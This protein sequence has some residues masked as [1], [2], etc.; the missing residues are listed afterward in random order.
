MRFLETDIPGVVV[1]ELEPH[2]DERGFFARAFCVEEFAAR[3]LETRVAQANISYN[4]RA[5]TLRGLHW[6]VAPALEAKLFR[7]VRGASH[8]V[9]VDT[10]PSSP[11]HLRHVAVE[12][13]AETRRALAIPAECATGYQAIEDDTEVLYLVSGVYSPEHERG[14]RFDDPS[15]DLKWPL[16]PAEISDKDRSWPLLASMETA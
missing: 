3:G 16:P 14:L 6:Q 4:L 9:V 8:H 1:V 11:T 2:A 7:C 13:S 15:L 5:G 12:L 10:R